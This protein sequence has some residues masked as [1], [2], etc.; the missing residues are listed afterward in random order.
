MSGKVCV[1][2]VTIV[3]GT[4]VWHSTVALSVWS[5]ADSASFSVFEGSLDDCVDTSLAGFAIVDGARAGGHFSGDCAEI[6]D[7]CSA[8]R[9]A[10]RDTPRE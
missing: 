9:G 8:A 2:A 1:T 10:P 6:G 3:G 5:V 4:G 7:D